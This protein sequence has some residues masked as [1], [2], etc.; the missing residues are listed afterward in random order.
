MLN[1]IVDVFIMDIRTVFNC[2]VKP[3]PKKSYW[4]ITRDA[5]NPVNQS[6]LEA[7]TRSS[8]K[9]RENVARVSKICFGFTATL[10]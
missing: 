6:K 9:A 10:S 2:V 3:K 1:N 7:N 8:R 4:P 5:D